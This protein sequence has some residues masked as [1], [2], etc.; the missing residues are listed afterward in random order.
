MKRARSERKSSD[1]DGKSAQESGEL[2]EGL[3]HDK[4]HTSDECDAAVKVE[5]LKAADDSAPPALPPFQAA[6]SFWNLL[7]NS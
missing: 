1:E 4:R 7:R 6:C 3:S 2:S 5:E